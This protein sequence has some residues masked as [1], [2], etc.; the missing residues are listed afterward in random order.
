VPSVP[1]AVAPIE[2]VAAAEVAEPVPSE[3]TAATKPTKLSPMDAASA[4]LAT[5]DNACVVKAL[6]GKAKTARELE[7]LIETYRVL[8]NNDKAEKQMQVYVNKYPN[9]RHTNG[10]RRVLERRQSEAATVP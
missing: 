2:P 4:C 9:G 6:E 5:A 8:G 7:L 10:F 3:R 1:A